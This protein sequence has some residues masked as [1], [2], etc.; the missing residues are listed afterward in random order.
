MKSQKLN[1]DFASRF[2][3]L[4]CDYLTQNNKLKPFYNRFPENENFSKQIIE[5]ENQKIDRDTLVQVLLNQNKDF[6]LSQ[7]EQTFF[8]D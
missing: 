6:D 8:L 4:V 2:S 3:P 7:S 1:L 5:K